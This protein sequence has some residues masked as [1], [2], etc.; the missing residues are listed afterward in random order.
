MTEVVGLSR[1]LVA[2]F[3]TVSSDRKSAI[4]GAAAEN[5]AFVFPAGGVGLKRLPALELRH[6]MESLL[7]FLMARR[8]KPDALEASRLP[9][10]L[11]TAL[12]VV[13]HLDPKPMMPA[14]EPVPTMPGET[15]VSDAI[16][17]TRA[18][19]KA[20]P[21]SDLGHKPP[22][23]DISLLPLP[24]I[25]LCGNI[26]QAGDM[27]LVD[28]MAMAPSGLLT[29]LP[30]ALS[31]RL[32]GYQSMDSCRAIAEPTQSIGTGGSLKDQARCDY[33]GTGGSLKDQA[34]CDYRYSTQTI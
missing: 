12:A 28:S 4:P 26:S 31:S 8:L 3:S 15:P 22:P 10:A 30:S 33:I 27:A 17:L 24:N 13:S 23:D 9:E 32:T 1:S 20:S 5:N 11:S 6:Q 7:P 19:S 16:A 25:A 29:A 18:N 34:R 2:S 21:H 14:V